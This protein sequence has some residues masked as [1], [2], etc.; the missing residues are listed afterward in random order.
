MSLNI[1]HNTILGVSRHCFR[2]SEQ[3]LNTLNISV[4]ADAV[5]SSSVRT[6]SSALILVHS[7]S[8]HDSTPFRV[9]I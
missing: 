2:V 8:Q 6:L 1:Y 7:R 3:S 9:A 4:E 5:L